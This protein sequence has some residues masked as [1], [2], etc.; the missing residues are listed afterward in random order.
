MEVLYHIFGH[1]LRVSPL[2]FSPYIDPIHGQYL[3]FW[4]LEFQLS[5]V[6]PST[7]QEEQ[8]SLNGVVERCLAKMEMDSRERP[9]LAPWNGW[10]HGGG[11]TKGIHLGYFIFIALGSCLSRRLPATTPQKLL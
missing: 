5:R 11:T 10:K 2:K 1:I 4:I 9:F 7:P 8:Q 6:S 3:H